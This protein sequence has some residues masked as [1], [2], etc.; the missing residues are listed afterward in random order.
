LG[1]WKKIIIQAIIPVIASGLIISGLNYF[2][3][4]FYNKPFINIQ[5]IPLGQ[6]NHPTVLN[7]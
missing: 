5:I 4:E 3:N 1:I 6:T 7:R 2:Y